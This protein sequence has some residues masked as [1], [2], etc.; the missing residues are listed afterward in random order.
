MAGQPWR[1]PA[2]YPMESQQPR[3]QLP[4]YGFQQRPFSPTYPS[5]PVGP[6][7]HQWRG[8][9]WAQPYRQRAGRPR[10]RG[11][12]WHKQGGERQGYG[13]GQRQ[14]YVRNIIFECKLLQ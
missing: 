12:Y 5:G 10:G 13:R 4:H 2:N 8:R 6:T 7:Q 1:Y 9:G 14:H 3:Q 11:R